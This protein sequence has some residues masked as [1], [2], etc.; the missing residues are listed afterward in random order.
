MDR[1][2][3]FMAVVRLGGIVALVIGDVIEPGQQVPLANRVWEE[4]AGVVP[5]EAVEIALDAYDQSSKT[6]RVWGEDRKGRASLLDRILVLRR[7]AA[8][9]SRNPIAPE[10]RRSTISCAR[11]TKALGRAARAAG[12]LER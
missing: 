3:S 8:R 5:F 9:A 4:L 7:V 1:Y 6:T 11:P 10:T 12:D 2:L